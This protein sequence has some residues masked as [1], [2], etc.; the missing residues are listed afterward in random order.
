MTKKKTTTKGKTIAP[1]GKLGTAKIEVWV[2]PSQIGARP[3]RGTATI[4]VLWNDHDSNASKRLEE[5]RTI[6]PVR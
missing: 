1:G 3:A 2:P 4:V 6:G 5:T